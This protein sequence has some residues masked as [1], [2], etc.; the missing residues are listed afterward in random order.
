MDDV[1]TMKSETANQRKITSMLVQWVVKDNPLAPL[2]QTQ[3]DTLDLISQL[4][5]G[6]ET[7]VRSSLTSQYRNVFTVFLF[8]CVDKSKDRSED[9]ETWLNEEMSTSRSLHQLQTTKHEI[10]STQEF[11]T[12]YN[13]IGNEIY[14]R[15]DQK[16]MDYVEQLRHRSKLCDSLLEQIDES[17]NCLN[18]L[19]NE[20]KF[21]AN[22]TDSLNTASEQL[23]QEQKQLNQLTDDLGHRLQYF[24]QADVLLQRLLSPTTSVTSDVF[25][26][27]LTKINECITFL[28]EKPNFKE[29]SAYMVKYR[30]CLQKA[31]QMMRTYVNQII[32]TAAQQILVPK[33]QPKPAVQSSELKL[34]SA[35]TVFALFYGKFQSYASKVKRITSVIEANRDHSPEYIQLL[36]DLHQF[37]FQHRAM[38]MSPG[39]TSAIKNLADS[40]KGDH[41]ALVRSACAFLVHVCQDEHRLFFQFFESPSSQLR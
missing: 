8:Q 16:Y 30:H 20:Y 22:K 9:A 12:W 17:L 32:T 11:L 41:C 29:S 25:L 6:E 21:V 15:T 39:V 35:D 27:T 13:K 34:S 19:N 26:N 38:I 14:E 36:N 3:Q 2:T 31:T 23:I 24:S 7:D 33:D 1:S 10:E 28:K 4:V 40:H 37:Y 5:S 18:V